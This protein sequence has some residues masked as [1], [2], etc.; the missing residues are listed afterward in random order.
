MKRIPLRSQRGMTMLMVLILM[1]VM[2]LG[3]L[4][5]ARMTEASYLITGNVASKDASVHAAEVGW[6]TAFTAV[7][8]LASENDDNGGWYFA[9]TQ[10]V[11]AN[12]IPAINWDGTPTVA[13][14]VERYTVNYAVDRL[15]T[16]GEITVAS[17]ECLVKLASTTD[18]E[19]MSANPLDY[20][21][22]NSRQFRI[23][24]RVTDQRG[25]QTWTQ[26][27]VNR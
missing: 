23:T 13:G 22:K 16:I 20:Q 21:P 24:V 3:A 2:L 25:T 19:D 18:A 1:T 7:K 14:G 4:A 12:G 8:A 10:P 26:A 5:L 27:L 9:T 15:C 11:D 6:N 17:R